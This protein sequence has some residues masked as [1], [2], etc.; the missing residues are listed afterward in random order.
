MAKVKLNLKDFSTTELFEFARNI[1]T[2]LTGNADFLTPDPPLADVSTS[3]DDLETA[4]NNSQVARQDS[5]E[6]TTL[7]YDKLEGLKNIVTRLGLYV[8]NTSSGEAAKIQ[9][10]GMDVRDVPGA[11]VVPAVPTGLSAT[12]GDMEG[13]IDLQWEPVQ[14]AVS[15]AIQQSS[16]P[17]GSWTQA[18][19]ST[20]SK[21]SIEN[22]T[23]GD[24]YWFRVAAV[25][26]AGQSG[27]SDPATRIAP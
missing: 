11:S 8:E 1:V 16:D 18:A 19:I 5:Q 9:S 22:L 20:K 4:Y 21:H 2:A 7:M 10:A 12:A 17:P 6:K 26:T 23:S 25:G 24:K 15:Y 27:W 13:E 3:A 14:R